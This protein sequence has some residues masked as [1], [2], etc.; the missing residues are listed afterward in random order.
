VGVPWTG[1]GGVRVNSLKLVGGGGAPGDQK[2]LPMGG[3]VE[4]NTA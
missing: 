4:S 3:G 2:I 1:G